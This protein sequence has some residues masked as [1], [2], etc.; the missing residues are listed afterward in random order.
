MRVAYFTDS[1]PPHTDGVVNTLCRLID[2][3]T[4]EKV[5]FQFFSPFK[6]GKKI[7][8]RE[9]VKKNPIYPIS[10]LQGLSSGIPL[11]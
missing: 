7:C 10:S 9:K 2:T 6:P 8:W 4:D 11:F 5:D 3:L 1:L